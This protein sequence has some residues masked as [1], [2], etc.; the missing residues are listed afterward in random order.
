MVNFITLTLLLLSTTPVFSRPVKRCAVSQAVLDATGDATASV[1]PSITASPTATT[2]TSSTKTKKHKSSTT[3]TATSPTDNTTV[4]ATTSESASASATPVPASNSSLTD[5]VLPVQGATAGWTVADGVSAANIKDLTLTNDTFIAK[6]EAH[7]SSRPVV[8]WQGKTAIRAFMAKGSLDPGDDPAGGFSFYTPGPSNG[9]GQT[10]LVDLTQGKELL[11]SYSV[12]FED[13]FDFNLGG[14]LPGMFGG[15][16]DD[17]AMTCSG[18]DHDPDCFSARL[19]FRP[20]GAGELYLYLPPDL[21]SNNNKC[22]LQANE[23]CTTTYGESAGR[24][25]WTFT[26]GTW[27]TIS[28]RILLNT[29]GQDD[30]EA[31][32]YVDGQS[33]LKVPNITWRSTAGT[34]VRGAQMQVFFGGHTAEWASPKDQ[35]IWFADFTGAILQ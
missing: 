15:S 16:S 13:D 26:P 33:V 10:P 17:V 30:G 12:M 11:F 31:E 3:T 1:T 29:P 20:G 19:M 32:I 25:S 2:T 4:S 8:E 28:E 7:T 9:D 34:V 14:K 24:G 23:A 22:G 21:N 35:N 6:K 5:E 27:Q 18:G